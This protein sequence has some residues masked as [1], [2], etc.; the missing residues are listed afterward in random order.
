VL[1]HGFGLVLKM[2]DT[3]QTRLALAHNFAPLNH[4][5]EPTAMNSVVHSRCKRRGD[6]H[7]ASRALSL[8]PSYSWRCVSGSL[9]GERFTKCVRVTER[10]LTAE[11]VRGVYH[12]SFLKGRRELGCNT[13]IT[14][15][16]S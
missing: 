5:D 9:S 8:R 15:G 4:R 7:V 3:E 12:S 1:F 2:H 13:Y 10:I 16:L 6:A 14:V 11:L